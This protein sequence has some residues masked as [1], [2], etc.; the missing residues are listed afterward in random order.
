M[1]LWYCVDTKAWMWLGVPIGILQTSKPSL[2]RGRPLIFRTWVMMAA[3]LILQKTTDL[4]TLIL[5]LWALRE[6]IDI[7]SEAQAHSLRELNL[8][9]RFEI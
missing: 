4:S 1:R 8:S 2:V 6:D 3:V 9:S 7:S 5:K